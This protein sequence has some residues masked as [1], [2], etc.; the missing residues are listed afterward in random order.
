MKKTLTMMVMLAAVAASAATAKKPAT[1][2]AAKKSLD[3]AKLTAKAPEVFKARFETTKGPFVIEVHRA[4]APHGAD[5]FYNL[6]ANGYYDDT[7]FF[8]VM[9][10]FMAQFGIN[11]DPAVNAVWR[12]ANIPDDPVKQSNTPGMVTYATRGP[13]TRTTQL[14]INFGNNS[15]LDPQGFTPFGKVVEGMEVVQAL[16]SGYGDAPPG[17]S[18]PDQG[19]A[20]LEGNKY[21]AKEFP[22]LDVIKTARIVK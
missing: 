7:R 15:F 10:G 20:Q 8:R 3:P 11:G 6:V 9:D 12:D 13:N 21:L 14:F 16:Y 2:P 17:G 1:K 22:K 4:W 18:G 19:R 5:R